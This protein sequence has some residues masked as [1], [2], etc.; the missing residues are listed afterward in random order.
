[1]Q[2]KCWL[3]LSL[4]SVLEK[5]VQPVGYNRNTC[6]I[7]ADCHFWQPLLVPT[8]FHRHLNLTKYKLDYILPISKKNYTET[9]LKMAILASAQLLVSM[10][11][12]NPRFF[13]KNPTQWVSSWFH[14]FFQEFGKSNLDFL[15]YSFFFLF[16]F[17]FFKGCCL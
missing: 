13:R 15:F 9:E 4:Y 10:V 7:R 3:E 11:G 14:T 1:M 5:L 8:N 17:F 2:C 12:K 6:D 16:F